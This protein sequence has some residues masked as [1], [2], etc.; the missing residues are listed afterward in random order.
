[1]VTK[2]DPSV[3]NPVNTIRWIDATKKLPAR[4]SPCS[5]RSEDCIVILESGVVSTDFFIIYSNKWGRFCDDRI[6]RYWAPLSSLYESK[7]SEFSILDILRLNSL[8]PETKIDIACQPGA[9]SSNQMSK[10]VY[11]MKESSGLDNNVDPNKPEEVKEAILSHTN[12]ISKTEKF[13]L[14]WF[15]ITF[16]CLLLTGIVSFLFKWNS[17]DVIYIL[18]YLSILSFMFLGLCELSHLFVTSIAVYVNRESCVRDCINAL[19]EDV[20]Q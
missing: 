16:M 18:I 12:T 2:L 10:W 4:R 8:S 9:L 3:F 20:E 6:I 11:T 1:M 5:G 7:E 19:T 17:D 13:Y 14:T 15:L